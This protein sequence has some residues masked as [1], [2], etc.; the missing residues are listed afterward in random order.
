MVAGGRR[1]S[2]WRTV[3]FVFLT[4]VV[5]GAGTVAALGALNVVDLDKLAFWREKNTI[6]EGWVGIPICARPIPAYTEVTRDYLLNPKGEKVEFLMDYKPPEKARELQLKGVITDVAEILGRVTARDK[7]AAFYFV[8]DDFLPKGTRPGIVG[9]TPIGKRAVTVDASKLLGSVH[10]LKAGDHL[11]IIASIPIDMP[12]AGRG[13]GGRLGSVVASPEASLLPKRSLIRSLVQ[14]GIVV[15]PVRIRNVPIGMTPEGT[16]RMVPRQEIVLAVE[17]EEVAPLAEALDM[18]YEVMCVAR[19]GRAVETAPVSQRPST[20]TSPGEPE[21]PALARAQAGGLNPDPNSTQRGAAKSKLAD[22]T[23][24]YDPTSETRFMELMVGTS[25]Q[26]VVF[27][28]PGGSPVVRGQDD[29]SGN[30]GAGLQPA[31]QENRQ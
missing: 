31:A 9:G 11:D 13:L 19:S 22:I 28:G 27:A 1:R 10:E 24:G 14:D 18:K 29:G 25:R 5:G 26:F 7:G 21:E 17:P 15:S 4:L 3:F 12:G 16:P 30:A 23:P 8:E 20:V 2:R 6:P